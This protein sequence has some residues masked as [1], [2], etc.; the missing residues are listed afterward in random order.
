MTHTS[1]LVLGIGRHFNESDNYDINRET[2]QTDV[3]GCERPRI[4][5]V[6][7]LEN[8]IR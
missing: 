1:L 4:N 8:L 6:G 3:G 2:P 5:S 7:Q